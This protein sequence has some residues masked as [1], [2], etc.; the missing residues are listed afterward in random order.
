MIFK[1]LLTNQ[2]PLSRKTYY[3]L[4]LNYID[5]LFKVVI[6]NNFYNYYFK[7]LYLFFIR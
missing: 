5:I 2:V 6:D 1:N 7:N 4:Q 3:L